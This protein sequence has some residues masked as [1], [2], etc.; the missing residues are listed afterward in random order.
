MALYLY[1]VKIKESQ[2][3]STREERRYGEQTMMTQRNIIDFPK[4]KED[5]IEKI[6]GHEERTESA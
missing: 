4:K 2:M 5:V 1:A 3:K 6:S